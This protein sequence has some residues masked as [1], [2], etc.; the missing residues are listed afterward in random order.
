MCVYVV[1]MGRGVQEYSGVMYI[2]L[3]VFEEVMEGFGVRFQG[4]T[5]LFLVYQEFFL[6]FVEFRWIQGMK[7]L[8]LFLYLILVGW[9]LGFC[10]FFGVFSL[11]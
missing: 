5:F 3:M 8:Q 10:L 9:R 4:L 6:N 11:E 1:G 7:L 2:F